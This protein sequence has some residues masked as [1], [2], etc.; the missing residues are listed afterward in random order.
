[1]I[2]GDTKRRRAFTLVELLVVIAVIGMLMA[3]LLPAIQIVME[4]ARR[5]QCQNNLKQI[6]I[7]TRGFE[8]TN[9]YLPA[10][11]VSKQYPPV[12]NHPYTFFRWSALAQ[13]LPYL[14]QQNTREL[15]DTTLPLYMPGPGYPIS[16]F[17]KNGVSQILPMFLCPS[18]REARVDSRFGP[19]NYAFCA[20]T[21]ING[22]T[23]FDTDGVFYVNSA[24]KSTDIIDGTSHTILVSESLL[25]VDTLRNNLGGFTN[26]T[27]ERT[28]KF[29]M[30]FS[31]TPDLT[32]A[33]CQVAQLY[34]SSAGNGNDPRGFAWA[35]GEYRCSLYNHYYTPNAPICECITSVVVDP[36]SP[37]TKL[38]SAYGWRAARSM[39]PG[40]VNAL[41]ADG[42]VR[43]VD[44]TIDARIWQAMATRRGGDTAGNSDH[45]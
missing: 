16:E 13:I 33:K 42:G 20:G 19:T 34:N 14:E 41:L 15:L 39:H 35:S 44:E 31:T 18:D 30:S 27:P 2:A 23:P 28:Y 29:V 4:G 11:L 45:P 7:A 43:F 5:I 12:P 21:G 26:I 24:T 25:G 40:G 9:D 22:G 10:G 32:D 8:A 17:N 36:A 3:V 38:Y 6:G 1:M 37:P